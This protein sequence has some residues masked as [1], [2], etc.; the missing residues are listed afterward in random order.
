MQWWFYKL[1]D[2]K[3]EKNR[4]A[5]TFNTIVIL[6]MIYTFYFLRFIKDYARYLLLTWTNKLNELN[7]TPRCSILTI[8]HFV[9][10]HFFDT[11]CFS[12]FSDSLTL[13]LVDKF[14]RISRCFMFSKHLVSYFYKNSTIVL[15]YLV[16]LLYIYIYF[17]FLLLCFVFC[18]CVWFFLCFFFP[19]L[20]VLELLQNVYCIS[21]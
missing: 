15:I 21:W 17:F 10:H 20:K 13:R 16:I 18:V 9:I 3:I 19:P 8:R 6:Y 14:H 1:F 4:K 5:C 7:V 11:F 12:S 2:F